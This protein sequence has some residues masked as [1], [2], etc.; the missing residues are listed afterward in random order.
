ML[1]GGRSSLTLQ[2]MQEFGE[3]L[4]LAMLP[5]LGTPF[6]NG[7]LAENLADFLPIRPPPPA[8]IDVEDA[9]RHGWLELR[10]QP[11]I[12]P[13]VLALRGAEALI[14][15]RH[16]VL[17]V[18]P[19]A[20]FIPA[21]DDP[22]FHA[23]SE[24]V[25]ARA[26]ADWRVFAANNTPVE[27]SINLPLALLADPEFVEHMRLQLPDHPAFPG[28]LVEIKSAELTG[29]LV[30]ARSVATRLAAYGIRVAIDDVASEGAQ[31]AKM[32][33]CPF[34]E[35][36]VDW[37][38]QEGGSPERRRALCAPIIALA[39]RFGASTVAVGIETPA[40]L[41]AARDLGFSMVQ[42]FLF[43]EPMDARKFARTMLSRRGAAFT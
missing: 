40:D 39:N 14:R 28:L 2:T 27:I 23:L 5:P 19:P 6:R 17:G 18:V 34:A 25:V 43:A 11:K 32:T 41:E 7:D 13:H 36:K 4:G 30:L 1:F 37:T 35:L 8:E 3:E 12:D 38:R 10:Y 15:M 21:S 26:L 16:P 9:L 42:G 29:N 24:F 22:N 20:S 31:L 33:D